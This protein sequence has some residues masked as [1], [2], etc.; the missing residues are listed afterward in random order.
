MPTRLKSPMSARIHPYAR[1]LVTLEALSGS[2]FLTVLVARLVGLEM[3]WRE[4][5]RERRRHDDDH[6]PPTTQ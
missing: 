2:L 1:S 6:I 5:Q 4:E 3:E